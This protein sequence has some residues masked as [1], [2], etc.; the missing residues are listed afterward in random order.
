MVFAE[1]TLPILP[2]LPG[3][4]IMRFSEGG[5]YLRSSLCSPGSKEREGVEKRNQ[6]SLGK[7]RL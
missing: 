6:F 1:R 3:Q 5:V 2:T 7:T 4:V